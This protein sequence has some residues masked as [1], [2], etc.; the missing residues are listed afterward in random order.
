MDLK[1]LEEWLEF[2]TKIQQ[3]K[4]MITDRKNI[5]YSYPTYENRGEE[6]SEELKLYISNLNKSVINIDNNVFNIGE[7]KKILKNNNEEN[8]T[9]QMIAP[10]II[11][12]EIKGSIIFYRDI[13]MKY[14]K[15]DFIQ[16][17]V[18]SIKIAKDFIEKTIDKN[19]KSAV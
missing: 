12:D 9:A 6:L 16:S 18:E 11:D 15:Q 5:L 13:T 17:K 4:L 3:V 1:D 19:K 7:L 14:V 8:Y 10:I 2:I